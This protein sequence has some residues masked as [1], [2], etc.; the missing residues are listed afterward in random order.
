MPTFD[1]NNAKAHSESGGVESAEEIFLLSMPIT[2][3]SLDA[4]EDLVRQGRLKLPLDLRKTRDLSVVHP[5]EVVP[6]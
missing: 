5:L 2:G 1:R 3:V 6:G 4:I